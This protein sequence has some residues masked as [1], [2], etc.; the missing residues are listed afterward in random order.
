MP[1]ASWGP[2]CPCTLP[3]CQEARA[4]SQG[5]LILLRIASIFPP[6]HAVLG[7]LLPPRHTAGWRFALPVRRLCPR[8]RPPRVAP[9]R[10]PGS[11]RAPGLRF[12]RSPRPQPRAGGQQGRSAGRV[13]HGR[14]VSESALCNR[15]NAARGAV[16]DSGGA[17]ADQDPAPQ[18]SP[19]RRRRAGGRIHRSHVLLGISPSCRRTGL[20]SPSC[21]S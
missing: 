13:W 15:I 18:G 5:I 20:R 7:C 11:R 3:T 21:R 14:I 17:A 2:P 4:C 9:G 6:G 1:T 8:H 19:L 10:R 16:G 12:A